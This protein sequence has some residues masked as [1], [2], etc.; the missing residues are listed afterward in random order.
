MNGQKNPNQ[1]F[2]ACSARYHDTT[3]E[4]ASEKREH[5]AY[6]QYAVEASDHSDLEA[7]EAISKE[8]WK[9]VAR[10]VIK[11]PGFTLPLRVVERRIGPWTCSS[12]RC[13]K[14][15]TPVS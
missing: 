7:G 11:N 2:I 10:A 15:I 5:K 6:L 4:N 3:M 14:D 1:N 8:N 12:R 9:T 13:G